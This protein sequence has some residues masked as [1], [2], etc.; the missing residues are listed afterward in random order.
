LFWPFSPEAALL[1]G[2]RKAF[3][4]SIPQRH[5]DYLFQYPPAKCTSCGS[6]CLW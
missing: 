1:T 4:K 3:V 6:P 2:N 5:A